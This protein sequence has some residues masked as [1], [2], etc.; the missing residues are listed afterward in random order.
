MKIPFMRIDRQFAELR[1]EALPKIMTVF[2]TGR[3]LQSPEIEGLERRLAALHAL[4]H[5]VAVNSGTDALTLAIAGLKLPKGSAVAVPAMTFIASAS[6]IVHN[7]CRPV[8]IDVDPETMLMDTRQVIALIQSGA[9]QAVVVVHLYGQLLELDELAAVAARR[10]VPIIEDCAQALGATRFGKGPGRHGQ[11]TCLSFDPTKVI[12]AA[13]SGGALLTNDAEVAKI[14]R[15]LR[16]H[17][18]A[19][20]RVY[21]MVGYN[22]QMDSI[23][24]AVIDVKLNHLDA[25]QTRRTEIARAFT[26]EIG[27]RTGIRPIKTLDGNVHNHHKFVL[28]V[29]RRDA[30]Q[31]HL[32]DRGVQTSVHYSIPLH[33]QP[34]FA[35]FSAGV[36]L[37]QVERMA[38][39][40]LSLPM[41]AELTPEEIRYIT[42]AIGDFQG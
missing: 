5:C 4:E 12:G 19:G 11:V 30:L 16:Y 38:E 40:I 28:D 39:R 37:P 21:D 10:G 8:F 31:K 27:E 32:A 1:D 6:A 13:G 26:S 17:G 41:Y 35:S 25:W 29:E 22:W 18:H 15:R 24:A 9:V 34:C 14:G 36:S 2:E 20:N 42:D 7:D 33:R 23:Q 3:V